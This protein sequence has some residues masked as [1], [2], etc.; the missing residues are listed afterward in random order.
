MNSTEQQ[1][2]KTPAA[3]NTAPE[4]ADNKVPEW[5]EDMEHS[6]RRLVREKE[7]ERAKHPGLYR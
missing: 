1:P 7:R 3:E 2:D 6:L 4:R 5:A